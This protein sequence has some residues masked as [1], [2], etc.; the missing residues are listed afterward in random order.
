MKWRSTHS[1]AVAAIVACTLY[2]AY[3]GLQTHQLI[4]LTIGGFITG[5]LICGVGAIVLWLA[6]LFREIAPHVAWLVGNVL[7]WLG[8]VAAV[9]CLGLTAVGI[10]QGLPARMIAFVAEGAAMYFI[11]GWGAR[12][13]IAPARKSWIN[14]AKNP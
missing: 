5:L 10:Y 2:G 4:G 6:R 9:W 7:F 13:L 3:D 8:V 12:R 1:F 14:P 11:L